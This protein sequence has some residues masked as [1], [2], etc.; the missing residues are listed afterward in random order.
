MAEGIAAGL[1]DWEVRADH[2]LLAF[3]WDP[4]F[5]AGQLEQLGTSREQVWD[6]LAALGVGLPQDALPARDSRTYGPHVE[7]SLE[8][9]S[10]LRRHF[11]SVLPETASYTWNVSATEEK[12]WVSVTEG[13]DAR[14]YI[15]KAYA[16]H[17]EE[18]DA[19][20]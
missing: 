3:L 6:R 5:S 18:A 2:L 19:L 14:E 17:R 7:V 1:G 15:E 9:L 4:F 12:G 20:S 8:E 11:F 13:L 10:I 16:R